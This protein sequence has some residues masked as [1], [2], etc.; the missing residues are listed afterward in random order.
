MQ[1]KYNYLQN[2]LNINYLI[3]FLPF[4]EWTLQEKSKERNRSPKGE[5]SEGKLK[6]VSC[7]LLGF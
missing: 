2:K 7:F 5:L 4:L 3:K 6:S 1:Y